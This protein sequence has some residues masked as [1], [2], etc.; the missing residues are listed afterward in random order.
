MNDGDI[1]D[2]GN[3]GNY[4]GNLAVRSKRGRY[5]WSIENYSGHHWEEI[6]RSL[7]DELIKHDESIVKEDMDYD[8]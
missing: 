2:I 1:K 7:F 3:I 8:E 4:Y 5:Y 6:P